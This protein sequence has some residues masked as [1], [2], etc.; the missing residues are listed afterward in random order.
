MHTVYYC[1]HSCISAIKDIFG[2]IEVTRI[3]K[4]SGFTEPLNRGSGL[5]FWPFRI[6]GLNVLN[7]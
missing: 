7:L 4:P 2:G 6:I 1:I 5:V 3:E